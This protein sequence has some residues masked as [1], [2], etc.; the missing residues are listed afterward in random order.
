M[1]VC[2]RIYTMGKMEFAQME[3][4]GISSEYKQTVNYAVSNVRF[5]LLCVTYHHNEFESLSVIYLLYQT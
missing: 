4:S 5:E 3:S 2:K 1:R